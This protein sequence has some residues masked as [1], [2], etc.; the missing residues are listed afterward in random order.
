MS[1][2]STEEHCGTDQYCRSFI[3]RSADIRERAAKAVSIVQTDP[4]MEVIIRPYKKE[5]T[6]GKNSG[7]W[8]YILTPAAEQLGYE[9][10]ETLHRLVCC[11]LYGS[12]KIAFAGAVYDVPNRTTTHPK[13]M[14]RQ[15]FSDHC[16]R[17]AALLTAQGVA[18]PA[19][20]T[21]FA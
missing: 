17:A 15:E 13:T 7:Y 10:A 21:W 4:I 16:E 14:N 2:P 3:L 20:E 6:L 19:Q 8:G 5:R 9:S 12:S 11:E 1:T 18:L